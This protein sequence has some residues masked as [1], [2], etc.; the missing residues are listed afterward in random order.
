M[1]QNIT[2]L[3]IISNKEIFGTATNA[4][5][6]C[7]N[8]ITRDEKLTTVD[9]RTEVRPNYVADG[10]DMSKLFKDETMVL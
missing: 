10:Q 1:V 9:I 8:S 2:D 5:E 3:C 6:V 4:I 7:S